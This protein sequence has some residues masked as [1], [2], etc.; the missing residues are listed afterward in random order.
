MGRAVTAVA[1]VTSSLARF[2]LSATARATLDHVPLPRLFGAV[3]PRGWRAAA[4]REAAAARLTA[5]E[6]LGALADVLLPW[7][8]RE[9]LSRL[10]V[11]GLVREFVDVDRIAALLDVDAVAARLDVDAVVDRVDVASVVDRVD[12]DAIAAGLDLN[13]LVE[14]VDVARVI[15]RVDL[16]EIVGRVD[17]DRVAAGID[18]D[19]IIDRVDVDR[20]AARLDLGRSRRGRPGRSPARRRRGR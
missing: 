13:A 1:S 12:L 6:Q 19:R 10:D 17:I 4:A 8:A 7:V 16:D 9:V 11:V 18:L 2:A 15:D 14:K 3:Q 5:E 20:V